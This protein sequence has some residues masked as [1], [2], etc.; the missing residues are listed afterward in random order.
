[1]STET[2]VAVACIAFFAAV[3]Q[4]VTAFGFALVMVPLLSLAWE[5]KP[6]VVTSTLLSTTFMI[7][8]LYGVRSKIEG[9]AIAPLLAG[10]FLG[11]PVGVLI[12]SRLAGDAL[13]IVVAVTVLAA[14]AAVYWSPS[15]GTARPHVSV[16]VL[17][18]GISGAL[19]GATS[20]SGPP[21]VL[22]ALSSLGQ[23][24]DRFRA[25]V[26]GVL[27]PASLVTIAGLAIA[28]LIDGDVL[29][30]CLAA[31]PTMMVGTL[32]GAWVR[33][34]VSP[35]VFRPIVLLVLVGSSVVVFAT[36]VAG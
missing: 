5:V 24:V 2:L 8:L 10:S 7:P 33:R 4:S 36:A 31:L 15:A 35:A 3:C 21:V 28:G 13:Q 17:A 27:L 20:M 12:L 16:A 19:R 1:M 32:T 34:R 11:I 26:F 9:R 29:L 14:S 6:A 23:E 18:G 30:A 25:N 22:Y